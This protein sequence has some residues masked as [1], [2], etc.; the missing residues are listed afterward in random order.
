[1]FQSRASQCRFVAGKVALGEVSHW[2]LQLFPTNI[3]HWCST[4]IF[5]LPSEWTLQIFKLTRST[6]R[7]YAST[8]K[9][10][11]LTLF[12]RIQHTS[13]YG[14]CGFGGPVVSMLVSGTQDRGFAPGQSR[15]IILGK[16]ILSMPSFGGEVKPFAPCRRFA[17]CQRTL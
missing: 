2:V 6:L 17:A 15:Q 3:I 11:T 5:T 1:L 4:L 10:A 12:L 13:H 7:Y 9:K 16:K 8:V 14:Y